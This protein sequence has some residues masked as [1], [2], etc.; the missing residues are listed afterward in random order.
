MEFSAKDQKIRKSWLIS[1]FVKIAAPFLLFA[2]T[3]IP[4]PQGKV[5]IENLF[6][7]HGST[8]SFTGYAPTLTEIF[9]IC[10]A[11][12]LMVNALVYFFSYK[13]HGTKLITVCLIFGAINLLA[14]LFDS[15]P[16]TLITWINAGVYAWWWGLS[17]GL[18]KKNKK[19]QVR[20][21]F[22]SQKE[23]LLKFEQSLEEI[24]NSADLNDL[25]S[26]YQRA[27]KEQPQMELL[28][29]DE[30]KAKKQILVG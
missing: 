2:C 26:R 3:P 22:L 7:G 12:V 10:A 29:T 16:F 4:F 1:F 28:L 17:I 18:Q 8:L 11:F 14:F 23:D 25:D 19:A 13:R 27:V 9:Y 6:L 30:Y 21:K 20:E 24:R 15:S 5:Y